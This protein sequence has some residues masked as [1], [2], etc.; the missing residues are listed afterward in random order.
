[1]DEILKGALSGTG[2]A[3]AILIFHLWKLEPALVALKE[4][5]RKGFRALEEASYIRSKT[6]LLK[7]ISS[8]L[9]APAVKDEAAEMV[10]QIDETENSK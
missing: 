7:M 4:E 5:I 9:V 6:D 8:P 3:G 1:M 10:R 2:V